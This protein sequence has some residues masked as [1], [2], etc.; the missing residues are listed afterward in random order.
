MSLPTLP[1]A[2]GGSPAL[3][4]R[5]HALFAAM[6]LTVTSVGSAT[7]QLYDVV[8][9]GPG[10]ARAINNSGQVAYNTLDDDFEC[11]GRAYR[12]ED[13]NL[14]G[15]ATS[16]EFILLGMLPGGHGTCGHDINA[17][18]NI[19]G[20]ANGLCPPTDSCTTKLLPFLW[21]PTDGLTALPFPPGAAL[22]VEGTGHGLNNT[23][24]PRIVG[25]IG[26]EPAVWHWENLVP[27]G[28]WIP[29]ILPIPAVAFPRG[30]AFAI[31]N[32]PRIVG[33]AVVRCDGGLCF[34]HSFLWDL[35]G[36]AWVET[37]LGS[38]GCTN[39][40]CQDPWVLPCASCPKS[41]AVESH[42]YNLNE[43]TESGQQ[44]LIVVGES[45]VG[46]DHAF[47]FVDDG[48]GIAEPHEWTDLG[49]A[50]EC[51]S[52]AM[53]VNACGQI[54]GQAKS[55]DVYWRAV[56]SQGRMFI[57]NDLIDADA[58]W[59]LRRALGI[60]D[61]GQIVGFG[62]YE[63]A[64]QAFLL[65]PTIEAVDP[66]PVMLTGDHVSTSRDV[67]GSLDAR[68]VKGLAADG[69]TRIVLRLLVGGPGEVDFSVTDELNSTDTLHVG[70]LSAP[71]T[72]GTQ[73][74]VKVILNTPLSDGRWLATAILLA[75]IDFVRRAGNPSAV[76]EVS[77][78][79]SSQRPLFVTATYTPAAE[80]SCSGAFQKEREIALHR[81]PVMLIHGIWGSEDTWRWP[82]NLDEALSDACDSTDSFSVTNYE[83]PE[84]H[85]EPFYTNLI[86]FPRA[87]IGVAEAVTSLRDRDIAA[88]QADV[89]GHSMGGLLSRLHAADLDGSYL[90]GDDCADD[91]CATD[92]NYGAGDIHKLVT[93]DSPHFGSPYGCLL[94][95]DTTDQRTW[96]G[97]IASWLVG[98]PDCGALWD[99]R[100]EDNSFAS[101]IS[102]LLAAQYPPPNALLPPVTLPTAII[103]GTGGSDYLDPIPSVCLDP[104]GAIV[105]GIRALIWNFCGLL[106]DPAPL[107]AGVFSWDDH[108]VGVRLTS[109]RGGLPAD[110]LGQFD[111]QGGIHFRRWD[112]GI[113]ANQDASARAVDLLN[114]PVAALQLGFPLALPE[115]C[116]TLAKGR[117]SAPSRTMHGKTASTVAQIQITA[118]DPT[119]AILRPGE[120]LFVEVAPDA[121]YSPASVLAFTEHD[122]E[123]Q[124]CS[125][126]CDGSEYAP[127]GPC[128]ASN[129][130]IL[131]LD[132]PL[133]E[134]GI[135]PVA[136]FAYD[137]L[138]DIGGSLQ[139]T[140]IRMTVVPDA[141][142]TGIHIAPE[143]VYL[144]KYAPRRRVA[145]H[146]DYSDTDAIGKPVHRSFSG[147]RIPGCCDAICAEFVDE[148]CDEFINDVDY[149][150]TDPS[151]AEVDCQGF[152]TARSVGRTTLTVSYTSGSYGLCSDPSPSP[153]T[154]TAEIVVVSRPC[155]YDGDGDVDSDDEAAYEVCF[156]GPIFPTGFIRPSVACRDAFDLDR[157][158]D[159]DEDD[160]CPCAPPT[161]TLPVVELIDDQDG[162][163]VPNVKN[164]FL[165]FLGG[166]PGQ[167]QAIRVVFKD[168]PAPYH[169]WNGQFMWVGEPA[170]YDENGGRGFDSP[171]LAGPP[172]TD[173]T[174]WAATLQA[175]PFWRDWSTIP[176]GTI[177]V[178]GEGI[179][180]SRMA[181]PA[182]PIDHAALYDVEVVERC[183]MFV[184]ER[185]SP[186]LEIANSGWADTVGL[187]GGAYVP[188]DGAVNV[189]DTLAM[190]AIFTGEPGA[191]SKT[192]MDLLGVTTGPSPILDGKITVSDVVAVLEAF[193]GG[194][195]P[196][197]PGGPS[198]PGVAP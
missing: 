53:D 172:C 116:P 184:G 167:S 55:P 26:L 188:P 96:L 126:S 134:V 176:G 147:C 56:L 78:L 47:S 168:L 94:L 31:D 164:R 84:T 17:A 162:V 108:D 174:F 160:L 154:A 60:N 145:V 42:A 120:P 152:V 51:E 146:A 100:P 159:I 20:R 123:V 177:H 37:D 67:L 86:I 38:L 44:R 43:I 103:T 16:N 178:Y 182:G 113:P 6:L 118:P 99:M 198:P 19:A 11:G 109:Q 41:N 166:D 171:C 153:C 30:A 142:V 12:F 183:G 187:S 66:N 73:N 195:Y 175:D 138:N 76:V 151:V 48:D 54:V 149:V 161:P 14:D 170:E 124:Q 89:F 28:A 197:S 64:E 141:S 136:A 125:T 180:P 165:S 112:I 173:A 58:G 46:W 18:G 93:A 127:C 104:V 70:T 85:A 10:R 193:A 163:A 34:W 21:T 33:E 35:V 181:T 191:P 121:G 81:P 110:A 186:A 7:A 25:F 2:L 13:L 83:Y 140:S 130:A 155:D 88:T 131:E 143:T 144:F 190:V 15:I 150:I 5:P 82:L 189:F 157:D 107:I 139:E 52:E 24:P 40:N 196:F 114:A 69:V 36:P 106:C 115:L 194:S 158:T 179:V 9:L 61:F 27:P 4:L 169:D 8:L 79:C 77:D 122:G 50:G 101:S 133:D 135:L 97:T 156:S 49:T 192:R 119:T 117:E 22:N 95:D 132:V 63:N 1:G 111:C 102:A 98:C 3:R 137:D 32:D 65:N 92:N 29:Q 185:A 128:S 129:P 39:P 59:D 87:R 75:P 148:E 62:E 91:P 23:N 74:N 80:G 57:L 72:P 45:D 68:R 105:L 90:R 71:G